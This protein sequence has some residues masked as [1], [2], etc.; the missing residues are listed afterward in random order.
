VQSNPIVGCMDGQRKRRQ[1]MI[2]INKNKGAPFRKT[3]NGSSNK[4]RRIRAWLHNII[5]SH[6]GLDAHWIQNHI[7][8][9]PRCHRRLVSAGKVNLA[10]SVMKSQPHKLDLLMR[11]NTQAINVLKHSLRREPKAQK[12]RV[13]RPEPK[14]F[15]RC[16]KYTHSTANVAA[17]I[18][19]LLLM[20][21]GIFSSM[22]KFQTQ[23]QKVVEHY[24]A[25]Q[26]GEDLADE[27]FSA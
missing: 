27:V 12:L 1:R 14:L 9:C 25:S 15:E 8:N 10:L 17:C 7:V 26:V 16:S 5:S 18:A 3:Q 2:S 24:Y 21:I 22:D 23:G 13:M 19:I 11:A 6:L 4:C 20:K